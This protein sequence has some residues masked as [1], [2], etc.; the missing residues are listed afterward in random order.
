MGDAAH[1]AHFAIGSGTKLALEDAIELTRAVRQLGT[2]RPDPGVLAAYEE[3]RRV[4]VAAHPERGAQRD[5]VVRGRRR[6]YA[7]TLRAGAVHVFAAHALASA[8]AT[9]TCGCATRPGSKATSAGSRSAA[10]RQRRR[11]P[12]PIAA[13]VHALHAARRDAAEPHRRL[14]HGACTR[15]VDGVPDDFHL[16][17]LGAR[18]MGGAGL[19]F[20][21]MTCV[22][23]DARITPGCPGCGTT[24]QA[25]R[26]QRIVE[27]VHANDAAQ[28]RHAARPC[29]PQGLDPR[30]LGRRWTSR[31]PRATGR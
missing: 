24:Q 29:R 17:H 5:G 13:D 31:S 27:F 22:S 10:R 7:D 30:A 8:S 16:V 12:A 11:R 26:W 18:A 21:E 14:A 6:R 3:M 2:R 9:R 25:A 4:D 19:V 23:P 1:T 28:D 20:A 15:R